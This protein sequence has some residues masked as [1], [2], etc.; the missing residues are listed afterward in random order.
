MFKSE[1]NYRI[2]KRGYS[3]LTNACKVNM[4][5][6]AS[7]MMEALLNEDWKTVKKLST[8]IT[9]SARVNSTVETNEE[10]IARITE[11]LLSDFETG[12][13]FRLVEAAEYLYDT[14]NIYGKT[15][16]RWDSSRKWALPIVPLWMALDRLS[17]KGIV[18]KIHGAIDDYRSQPC[19]VYI[20]SPQ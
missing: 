6:I 18:S 4:T 10:M 16:S 13:P 2:E 1:L 19:F 3:Y 17:E 9:N 20:I 15:L 7:K 14:H 11:I 12:V 5:D 8:E